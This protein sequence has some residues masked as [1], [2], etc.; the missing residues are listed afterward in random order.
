MSNTVR[1]IMLMLKSIQIEWNYLWCQIKYGKIDKKWCE[2][3]VLL[4]MYDPNEHAS[5]SLSILSAPEKP[6]MAETDPNTNA[7]HKLHRR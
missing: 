6:M 5:F 7:M 3:N 4:I 1:D 2:I